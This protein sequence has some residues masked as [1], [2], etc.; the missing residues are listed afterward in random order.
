MMLLLKR[1]RR[2][3]DCSRSCRL[4]L[5]ITIAILLTICIVSSSTTS[6]VCETKGRNTRDDINN[7][8]VNANEDESKVTAEVV[9]YN[10]DEDDDYD[11]Y[12]YDY[13]DDEEGKNEN[14]RDIWHNMGCDDVFKHP[15]PIPSQSDWMHA[16]KIYRDI[17]G[18]DDA[19]IIDDNDEENDDE[20]EKNGFSVLIEA[21][22]SSPEKGRGIFALEDIKQGALVWS[23]S[24]TA[25]FKNGETYREFISKLEVGFACDVI[26]WSCVEDVG[27]G[28]LR[29]AVALDEG[30]F[31]ND[32]DD[33]ANIGS[34]EGTENDHALR[35]I[36]AGDELLCKYDDFTI[37][38]GWAE[39]GL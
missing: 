22:Q 4:R 2:R 35:D 19:T 10:K 31:C 33:D 13:G 20:K 30:C 28:E 38:G 23:T 9:N 14:I 21:K 3:S 34:S 36:K 8:N 15:R 37:A 11:N 6:T 5:L 26:L 18:E 7:C 17:V 39:F 25:R 16:R 27:D 24:K 32:G 29:I 1:G 12:D